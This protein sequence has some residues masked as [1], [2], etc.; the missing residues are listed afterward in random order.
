MAWATAARP[1][2]WRYDTEGC[3]RSCA[4]ALGEQSGAELPEHEHAREQRSH[5]AEAPRD[6]E[7]VDVDSLEG[8]VGYA[9]KIFEILEVALERC[10]DVLADCACVAGCPACVPSRP[11]GV[12]D[13]EL[14]E[15]LLESDAAVA[16]TTSL[17]RVLLTGRVELPEVTFHALPAGEA[18]EAPPEDE[19]ARKLNQRLGAASRILKTKRA[20]LH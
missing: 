16:C 17:V 10:R 1:E 18:V 9:E 14:E 13:E 5:R 20:R 7:Q 6:C 4:L 12:N 2:L 15:L 8:G 3:V 11:P 19:A